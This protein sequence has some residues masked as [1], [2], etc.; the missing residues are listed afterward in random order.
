MTGLTS[1]LA[2]RL[3]GSLFVLL[4]VSFVTFVALTAAPGDAAEA[5]VGDSASAEQMEVLRQLLGLD[6]PLVVR[7]ERFLT[8]LVLHGDLGRSMVSGRPV[9]DLL[10]ERLPYTVALAL[11]AG[12]TASVAGVLIGTAAA[13]RQGTLLDVGIM[14]GTALGLALP[15]IWVA[16]L[17]I[18]VFS[19]QLRWL[20]VV[21]A[22]S[23]RH[24]VLPALTLALPTVAIVARLTRSSLLD[25]MGSDYIR[26]AHGKGLPRRRVIGVH[27]MRN[28]LIPLLAVLSLQL[29]HLLAGSF[30]VETIFGWPGLGR[31]TVMA[32]FD[33]DIPVVMGAALLVATIYLTVNLLVDLSHAW[34]DPRVARDAV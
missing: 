8:N 22:G 27:A 2:R 6:L 1:H 12:L 15:S 24:I 5:M 14:G 34:L 10:L 3:A 21:G 26:T 16:M 31:L 17:L 30:I 32:I 28:S 29:G 4:A 7:Y 9:A 20:P 33:R 18:M 13:L 23:I 19:L 25:T 11:V